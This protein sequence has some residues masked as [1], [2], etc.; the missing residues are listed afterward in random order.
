M[1]RLQTSKT[2]L[3]ALGVALWR[4]QWDRRAPPPSC[5]RPPSHAGQVLSLDSEGEA[6]LVLQPGDLATPLR[7]GEASPPETRVTRLDTAST[8]WRGR[9]EGQRVPADN[10]A[11]SS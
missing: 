1:T 9:R 10:G 2:K 4:P 11:S 6:Q 8:D 3:K 7:D 5:S